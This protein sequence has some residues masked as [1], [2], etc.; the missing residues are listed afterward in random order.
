MRAYLRSRTELWWAVMA[1]PAL[2]LAHWIL[3][4]VVPLLIRL[5]LPASVQTLIHLL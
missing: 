2:I 1:L 3:V 4:C 5:A